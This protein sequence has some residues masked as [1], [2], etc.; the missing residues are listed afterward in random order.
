MITLVEPQQHIVKLWGE[1]RIKEDD[2]YRVMR[3]VVMV[4]YDNQTLL[5]NVVTGQLVVLDQIESENFSRLP[6]T[7]DTWMQPLAA[8]H[9]LVPQNYDE[10]QQ[11]MNLRT[12]LRKL[13]DSQIPKGVITQYSILPTTA[14][15]A[16]CYYC[17]EKGVEPVTMTEKTAEDVVKFIN[18]HCGSDRR[19]SIQ[20]FGGEPTIAYL[21]I[22]QICDGLHE[23]GINFTSSMITNG[24]LFDREMIVSAKNTWNLVS[25]QIS[26]DGTERQTNRIKAFAVKDDNPYERILRNVGLLIQNEIYV[27]LRMNFDLDNVSEFSP[28]LNQIKDLYGKSEF[29][30]VY[31]YPIVGDYAGPD[32][33]VHHGSDEWLDRTLLELNRQAQQSGL[34]K[35]KRLLPVMTYIG[36]AAQ[37]DSYVAILPSGNLVKCIEQ[38]GKD[39]IIGSLVNGIE[40][41]ALVDSWKLL[42]DYDKCKDCSYFPVCI[43]PREC[44][45]RDRC[46]NSD[47][48]D[49]FIQAIIYAYNEKKKRKDD[50]T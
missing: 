9:Y 34:L 6:L 40:N 18:D 11:V 38:L 2:V 5:H 35:P 47:R 36:C 49:E 4:D 45:G 48:H 28:L 20:W 22:N 21:R 7:F 16:R 14:C 44:S 24:F 10:H 12:V 41:Q 46:I 19:V 15:N 17:Y 32:G 29:L 43:K 27:G 33:I 31:A 3:Y 30:R 1:Q 39:Q 8:Q 50:V 23:A 25:L 37:R 13:H 26:I 42:A